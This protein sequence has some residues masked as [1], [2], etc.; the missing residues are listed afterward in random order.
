MCRRLLTIFA[1]FLL[2]ISSVPAF[3]QEL[4]VVATIEP[5][6]AIASNVMASIGQPDVL[7]PAKGTPQTF[8]PTTKQKQVLKRAQLVIWIGPPLEKSV[9]KVIAALPRTAHVITVTRLPG[10]KLLPSRPAGIWSD[11][12]T[13]ATTAP[14]KSA[15]NP[16]L[17][18]DP[19]NAAVIARAIEQALSAIDS[20]NAAVYHANADAFDARLQALEYELSATLTPVRKVPFL[21]L[22][23]SYAYLDQTYRLNNVGT[24]IAEPREAVSPSRVTALKSDIE[25]L[26][27][28]CIFSEPRYR[29]TTAAKLA[30]GLG[31]HIRVLDT[32]GSGV[33]LGPNSYFSMMS[34]LASGI[35]D[36]L[37]SP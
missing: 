16:N 10:I 30:Q 33:T 31:V 34:R 11:A 19:A 9:A 7:I 24:V 22:H 5:L 23:D 6:G 26:Q 36:C 21:S 8:L 29:P 3:A 27:V 17:W 35:A 15:I 18:L 32:Y 28:H 20:N 4:N 25:R 14:G 13:V 1:V 37:S 12:G 2:S